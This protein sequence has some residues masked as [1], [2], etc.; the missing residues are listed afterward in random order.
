VEQL[1][2]IFVSHSSKDRIFVNTLALDL[3]SRG[4]DVW[5]DQW[6]LGVG[7]S[8]STVIQK[9]IMESSWLLVVLS[10]DSVSSRWVREELNAA[11]ARQLAEDRV[12][13]LPVLHRDCIMPVF[14]ADKVYA[15]FR[16]DYWEGLNKLVFALS[17]EYARHGPST[18]P[19][20]GAVF[21]PVAELS[22]LTTAVARINHTSICGM[23]R[24]TTG[25]LRIEESHASGLVGRYDWR[26][27]EYSGHLTLQVDREVLLF[28]WTWSVSGEKGKGLFYRRTNRTLIGGWW[29][30]YE[31]IDW[32]ALARQKGA[33]TE[34]MGIR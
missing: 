19:G 21:G 4:F 28:D 24:G 18:K 5:Y 17:R 1:M 16:A 7:D 32:G 23:W 30:A 9:G 22:A 33:A 12:Y 20:Y 10:P 14:L 2:N 27:H 34:P 8:I 13:I 29:F 15:D 31:E 26:G 3:R 6:E 25:R 11:F